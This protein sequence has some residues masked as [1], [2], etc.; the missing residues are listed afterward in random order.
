MRQPADPG[1]NVS[2]DLSALIQTAPVQDASLHTKEA[3]QHSPPSDAVKQLQQQPPLPDL[4]KEKQTSRSSSAPISVSPDPRGTSSLRE[5]S[6]QEIDTCGVEAPVPSL[7]VQ[8]SEDLPIFPSEDVCTFGDLIHWMAARLGITTSQPVPIVDDV[9]FDV[10]QLQT[11]LA[12]TIPMSKVMFQSAKACWDKPTLVRISS[13]KLDHLYCTQEELAEFLFKHL[14]PNLVVV[15][16]SSKSKWHYS[17]LPDRKGKK[18]DPYGCRLYSTGA[19]GIESMQ[20][21]YVDT[22]II[23]LRI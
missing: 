7:L 12:V 23:S 1:N 8:I 14:H 19:L 10:V 22:S 17:T 9:V 21:A 3:Q 16:S 18:L 4:E 11:P 2:A 13:K 15:S 6:D 5:E 20:C